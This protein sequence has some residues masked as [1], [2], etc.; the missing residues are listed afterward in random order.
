MRIQGS[1]MPQLII[2]LFIVGAWATLITCMSHYYHN[3]T[4]SGALDV[5][6]QL[7]DWQSWHQRYPANGPGIPGGPGT[8][9]PWFDCV[10]KGSTPLTW[11]A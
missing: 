8:L 2:P 6:L 7:I 10:R 5:E 3:R 1:V 9:I 11:F 4:S